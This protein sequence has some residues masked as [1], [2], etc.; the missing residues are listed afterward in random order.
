MT[1]VRPAFP[2][3]L[4]STLI[5]TFRSCPQKFMLEY[6]LHYKPRAESVHL[7]AGGAFAKGLE[8][9]RKAFFV[10][11]RSPADAQA[12]GMQA[13]MSAYGSF[14]CPP[15]SAKSCERMLGA[16][17]Y[18]FDQ[19]P[20]ETDSAIPIT[21]PSGARGIEFSFAEPIDATH[22]ETGDPLIYCGRMDAVVNFAEGVFGLDDKTTSSLGAS[23]SRQWDLRSQFSG[24]TWAAE[25]AGFPMQGFLVR[26]ISIL[27]TRYDTQ[28]ALTYRPAWQLERW[29]EQLM[30][31]IERMK[32][33][34]TEGYWDFALDHACTEFGSCIFRQICMS[35]DP[36]PWLDAGFTKRIWNPLLRTEETVGEAPLTVDLPK[37]GVA[38]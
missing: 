30:R 18:Y 13:L 37:T 5:A 21:L 34:W 22:P 35:H 9:A 1:L 23:W 2:T 26:G 19:Y 16:L 3:V 8:M 6:M 4:D 31:D 14:A 11:G 12:I 38:L 17:E 33:C 36:E 27:K 28:Q 15:D 10:E 25:R 29:Y 7:V 32:K 20:L 24:Y